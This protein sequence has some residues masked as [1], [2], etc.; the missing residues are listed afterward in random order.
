MSEMRGQP[1]I[2][3][4]NPAPRHYPSIDSRLHT[5]SCCSTMTTADRNTMAMSRPDT[6]LSTVAD[7]ERNDI[8]GEHQVTR[9]RL[10]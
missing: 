6:M 1:V 4:I 5:Y 2:T 8:I 9:I 7:D 10:N 3:L